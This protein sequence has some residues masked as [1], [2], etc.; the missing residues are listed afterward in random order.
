MTK[1]VFIKKAK[2]RH[3]DKY[4]YSKVEY[5]NNK[6][7]VCIICP[8]HGEFWQIAGNHLTGNGCPFC[9]NELKKDR[10]RS[11]TE[12]FI[13]KAKKVFPGDR[14][15]Y[16]KVDYYNNRKKVIVICKD[17]GEFLTKPND[18]LHGHGCPV[19]R[20]INSGEK[21]RK[22]TEQ[23]II[24]AKKV[25]GDKYDYSKTDYTK[26]HEKI[27]I[28]CPEHGEFW[29][30]PNV[31][32]KGYGCP[33][34]TQSHLEKVIQKL[35]T[36]NNIKFEYEKQFD[37]LKNTQSMSIDFYL[38]DL[39]IGIEC[40]GLQHFRPVEWFGGVEAF[41]TC[42]GR[43]VLKNKLCGDNGVGLLYF[44][45]ENETANNGLY[46]EKNTFKDVMT[47][48]GFLKKKLYNSIE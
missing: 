21:L 2:D 28:I 38:P 23:F 42:V 15:D 41:K 40:Q 11:N 20:Y 22:T 3:G 32:L 29:H 30:E 46:T 7:K 12:E 17:H 43:D 27:C 25:H 5:K 35:L 16:S 45:K 1:E 18:F 31:H 4:D 14:Y 6:T 39:K 8:K 44:T 24:D 47:L 48:L 9:A 26:A 37:W 10:K 33:K 36:E 34:C 13:E 19:C